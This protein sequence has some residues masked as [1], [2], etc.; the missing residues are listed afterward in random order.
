MWL[1]HRKPKWSGSK[2]WVTLGIYRHYFS[3]PSSLPLFFFFVFAFSL[4]LSAHILTLSSSGAAGESGGGNDREQ[5][6]G[7]AMSAS[8][9]R[10]ESSSPVRALQAVSSAYRLVGGGA[11]TCLFLQYKH[12]NGTRRDRE[13]PGFCACH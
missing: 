8:C 2:L 3:P 1:K 4:S 10:L 9:H 11:Q 6:N 5:D 7:V 12:T 13:E